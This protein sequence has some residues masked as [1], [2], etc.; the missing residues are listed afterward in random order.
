MIENKA[1]GDRDFTEIL[2][3]AVEQSR[4]II[5]I[6][7]P[8]GAV[9][10]VNPQFNL[11]S[12]YDSGQ[13]VGRKPKILNSGRHSPE[14]YGE[15]WRRLKATGEWRGEFN[16]RRRDGSLYWESASISAIRG[17]TGQVEHYLKLGE[18]ITERKAIEA[19]LRDSLAA[20]RDIRE[21][22][23]RLVKAAR[24][25]VFTVFLAHGEVSHT[26]HY[27]GC[28]EI[29]GYRAEDYA[30]RPG[31]WLDMVL[32]EDREKVLRQ[33]E[34]LLRDKEMQQVE[35]RIRRRDGDLRWLRNLCIPRLDEKGDL[36]AYDGLISDITELKQ[37]EHQRNE[38]LRRT[39]DLA[40]IDGLTGVYN[41]RG[42]DEQLHRNWQVCRERDGELGILIVDIDHFKRINDSLGHLVGDEIL[43]GCVKVLSENVRQQDQICRYGGDELVVIMPLAG[44][45]ELATAGE[46]LLSAFHRHDFRI[47]GQSVP[48]TVSIGA[49]TANPRAGLG[50][51]QGVLWADAA[52]Y[53][54]KQNGRDQFFAWQGKRSRSP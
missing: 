33:I 22:Y 15:M 51:E 54:A 19:R 47:D 17:A 8:E 41:R 23:E 29:T 53:H 28:E 50:V 46:R 43:R 32:E 44:L 5:M 45:P 10:Y 49:A 12:G 31:L 26:V 7:D 24:S 48:L 21:R 27:P 36:F 4:A 40:L 34:R 37:A 16:N 42:F 14:F 39:R 3:R 11:I 25:F 20:L 52:L 9:E 2:L 38:L 1:M 30:A 6:T 13:V 18:D 35:H